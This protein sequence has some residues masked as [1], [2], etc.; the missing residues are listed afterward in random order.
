VTGSAEHIGAGGAR[1][2]V[3]SRNAGKIAEV[4]RILVAAL[5]SQAPIELVGLDAFPDLA[6]V[7]ETE[8]T[9]AGNA[10]LKARAA[11]SATGWP[12]IADDS[13]IVV[14]ALNG[15]PG[16]L[17]ARWAGRHGDDEANLA[18]L[19]AQLGDV[20]DERRGAT[21]VCAAGLVDPAGA[22]RVEE[23]R[24]AGRLLWESRGTGGFGYDPIF[25]PD[26]HDRTTAQL[27][28]EDKDALSHRGK[29]FRALAPYLV[30]PR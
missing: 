12:A 23:G 22:E 5:G 28:P 26:G 30:L 7:A 8:A 29:A 9:F 16:V 21:F 3:A 4:R 27:A 1:I 17:S 2:V 19:L 10:L 13:G 11:A 15:M 6:D 14:D 18:L 20:P 25:V 24:V